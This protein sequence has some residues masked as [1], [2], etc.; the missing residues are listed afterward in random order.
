MPSTAGPAVGREQRFQ[1][2]TNHVI[3]KA[4]TETAQT[5]QAALAL[6]DLTGI[7]E[8]TNPQPRGKTE[9]RRGNSWA[10]S[11]NCGSFYT[12][13]GRTG[14]YRGCILSQPPIRLKCAINACISGLVP[15]SG[16]PV[17]TVAIQTMP[18]LTVHR[19]SKYWGCK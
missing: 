13:Q 15:G 16:S 18:T 2:H 10:S 5:R 12:R 9:R 19:T 14:W 4:L 6:E 3:A 17:N 1:R 8:R 7:H 11:T